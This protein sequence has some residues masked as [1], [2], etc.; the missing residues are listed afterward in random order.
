M[1]RAEPTLGLTCDSEG[2]AGGLGATGAG[3][4]ARILSAQVS[5]HQLHQATLLPWL[6][7]LIGLQL[8]ATLAPDHSTGLPQLTL[9]ADPGTFFSLQAPQGLSEYQL[10]GCRVG[11]QRG[12]KVS[13]ETQPGD[14]APH[15][16]L[17]LLRT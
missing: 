6:Q 10:Q 5:Q 16:Q 7:V 15:T 12:H 11:R 13:P 17:A 2:G 4:L 9:Q 1:L 14:R 8:Q 3:I